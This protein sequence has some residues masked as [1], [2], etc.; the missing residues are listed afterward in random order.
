MVSRARG[1]L[2]RV[3]LQSTRSVLHGG[4]GW[5]ALALRTLG[6]SVVGM[7]LVG[8][9]ADSAATTTTTATSLGDVH[10]KAMPLSPDMCTKLRVVPKLENMSL[11]I[12]Q[13]VN[14]LSFK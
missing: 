3:A 9:T 4:G 8:A 7:G 11:K 1:V 10:S 6:D 12:R 13:H 2:Q 5:P 14:P